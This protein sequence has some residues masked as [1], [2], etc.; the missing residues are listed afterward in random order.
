MQNFKAFGFVFILVEANKLRCFF[1]FL[2]WKIVYTMMFL[3]YLFASSCSIESEYSFF[4]C[5]EFVWHTVSEKKKNIAFVSDFVT[6]VLCKFKIKTQYQQILSAQMIFF[7]LFAN[8][9]N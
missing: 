6:V 8:Y 2:L 7:F 9:I 4:V 3:N 5:F 1:F